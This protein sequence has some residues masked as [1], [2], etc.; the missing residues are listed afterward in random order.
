MTK[1]NEALIPLTHDHHHTLAQ[2]RRLKEAAFHDQANLN[3]A[4]DDF[5]NSYLG[6]VRHHFHEEEELFFA[7]L[8][9]DDVT[10]PLVLRAVA[11][12]LRLHAQV[13]IVRR[14]LSRGEVTGDVVTRIAGLLESHVR[15]EE[16]ELF[17]LLE[18]RS[19]RPVSPI[20][21]P[22]GG[23]FCDSIGCEI[24]ARCPRSLGRH[25]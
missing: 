11:D 22:S 20:S 6:R 2:A 12:H 7:A 10:G 5:L 15:F 18:Q 14:Q 19:P 16:Q 24:C 23:A 21:P 17:P 1:R 3:R 13:T 4:A 8:I 25:G 9:D